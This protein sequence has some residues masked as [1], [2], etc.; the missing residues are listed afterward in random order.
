MSWAFGG[1]SGAAALRARLWQMP[2]AEENKVDGLH[3][4]AVFG[5]ARSGGERAGGCEPGAA[6]RVRWSG[7]CV[8]G[9]VPSADARGGDEV[10]T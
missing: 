1:C 2:A 8:A 3:N 7:R 6:R 4:G 10:R 5:P 9:P